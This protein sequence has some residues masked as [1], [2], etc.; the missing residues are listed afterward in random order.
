MSETGKQY[1]SFLADLHR[2]RE[3]RKAI[4]KQKGIK[5]QPLSKDERSEIL[6]KTDSRCHI[7]GGEI[8]GAWDADH[9]LSHSKGG[10][11]SVDNYLPAHKI[12]NNYR[13]DYI[14]EEFQEILK[15]G[16]WIRT[17]IERETAIGKLVADKFF[18]YEIQKRNRRKNT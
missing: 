8:E 15:L 10:E 5:R 3:T 6:A 18:K 16:V 7:C 17:Q 14:A 4:E 1:A 13:W 11:H 2:L 12:C 9:V